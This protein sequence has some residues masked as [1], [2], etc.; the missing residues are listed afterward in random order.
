MSDYLF[1]TIFQLPTCIFRCFLYHLAGCWSKASSV[2]C[3]KQRYQ[4]DPGLCAFLSLHSSL[5]TSATYCIHTV[6]GTP[7]LSI[8]TVRHCISVIWNGP[9]SSGWS[10]LALLD[11]ISSVISQIIACGSFSRNTYRSGV[12]IGWTFTIFSW[13][14]V[15]CKS[16]LSIYVLNFAR[17]MTIFNRRLR[18]SHRGSD[19]T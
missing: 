15:S 8:T 17:N 10:L 19:P 14:Y 1:G 4:C 7:S 18:R 11:T 3:N 12:N 9:P 6:L 13:W 16:F 2:V 5:K